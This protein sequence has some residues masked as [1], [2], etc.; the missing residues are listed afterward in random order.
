MDI[1]LTFYPIICVIK[2]FKKI[3]KVLVTIGNVTVFIWS[4]P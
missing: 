1:N 2:A 3:L 4:P